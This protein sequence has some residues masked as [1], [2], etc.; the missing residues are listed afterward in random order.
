M[1]FNIGGT[2]LTSSQITPTGGSFTLSSSQLAGTGYVKKGT[3]KAFS[4]NGS[5]GGAYSNGWK[6]PNDTGWAGAGAWNV[7]NGDRIGWVVDSTQRGSDF[8]TS[9]GR[10]TASVAGWYVFHFSLYMLND[11]A[12]PYNTGTGYAH[13]QFSKNG[14]TGWNNGNTPYQIYMHGAAGGGR[15]SGTSA[16]SSG[17]A[18]GITNS[19][20][21][22]LAVNDY[23]EINV[24]IHSNNTRIYAPY[25]SFWGALIS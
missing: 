16:S 8:S 1:A 14:S 19:A 17:Y 10:F 18:D 7:L 21:M 5:T 15:D 20:V 24:Y 12:Y 2:T 4:A 3:T 9:T 6:Y 23:V 22:Q 25:S 13:P 11:I